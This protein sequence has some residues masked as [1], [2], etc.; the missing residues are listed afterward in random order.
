MTIIYLHIFASFHH[1]LA[2]PIGTPSSKSALLI[3][4]LLRRGFSSLFALISWIKFPQ[5]SN[6]IQLGERCHWSQFNKQTAAAITRKTFVGRV[7][8]LEQR[9]Y[10]N[11]KSSEK[12]NE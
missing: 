11:L 8:T 12:E 6:S 1:P 2:P 3:Q 4:V 9:I 10:H 7:T 5:I